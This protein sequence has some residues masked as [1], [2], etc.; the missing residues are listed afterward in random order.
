[1]TNPATAVP[2]VLDVLANDSD[3]DGHPLTITAVTT[4]RHG[5]VTHNGAT[6]TYTPYAGGAGAGAHPIFLQLEQA[7]YFTYTVSDGQGGEAHG[8]VCFAPTAPPPMRQPFCWPAVFTAR[9]T[10]VDPQ[11]NYV[12]QTLTHF[13]AL[14]NRQKVDIRIFNPNPLNTTVLL[15]YDTGI[16][17][18]FDD[19]GANCFSFPLTTALERFCFDPQQT[20]FLGRDRLGRQPVTRWVVRNPG[21]QI[22]VF[23]MATVGPNALPVSVETW[24]GSQLVNRQHY[25]EFTPRATSFPESVF[26][27]PTS[28][29]PPAP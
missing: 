1:M 22:S 6:V 29:P 9:A 15:R 12:D 26:A 10:L 25:L 11:N 28:C 2:L 8:L 17:Y 23:Q 27:V 19:A 14:A 4:A 13:D 18:Q 7:D 20:G 5:A 16:G 21:G 24:D 3:P